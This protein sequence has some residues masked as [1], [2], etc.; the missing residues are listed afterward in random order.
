MNFAIPALETPAGRLL[1]KLA[2]KLPETPSREIV[3]FGS[4]PLQILVEPGFL[5]KDCD[6]I[7]DE[8]VRVVAETIQEP[9]EQGDL[10][11]EV[12]D[13]LTFRTAIGWESRAIRHA[14]HGH[15]FVFPHP[16]DI[17]TSKIGRLEEKDLEAFRIVIARTGHPTAEEFQLH[18]QLAVD[19]YRPNFDEETGRDY[20]I[21]TQ[22]LWQS[23]YGREI[24]VRESIIIPA[25]ARRKAACESGPATLKDRLRHLEPRA[26]DLNG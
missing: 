20:V 6:I 22:I 2:K 24:D 15:T 9:G 4:A 12:C 17:L 19:L 14:I 11:F 23:I 7:G 1:Q 5:S 18:L 21:Q 3:V 13:P 10:Y 25:L 16:W 8:T 26:E